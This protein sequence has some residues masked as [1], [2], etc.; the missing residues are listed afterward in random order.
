[1]GCES[2][3]AGSHQT[4]EQD[5]PAA[6]LDCDALGREEVLEQLRG[7]ERV[8]GVPVSEDGVEGRGRRRLEMLGRPGWEGRTERGLGRAQVLDTLALYKQADWCAGALDDDVERWLEPGRPAT[9]RSH[10]GGG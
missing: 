5:G 2:A 1:M 8:E 10:R 4:Q 6:F 3:C 7:V 9:A